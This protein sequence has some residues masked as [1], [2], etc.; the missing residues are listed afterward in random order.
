MPSTV[1]MDR[2][3]ILKRAAAAVAP[4]GSLLIVDHAAAPPWAEKM[5]HHDFPAGEQV[6]AG[7]NLDPAE[8]HSEV[9]TV[10]RTTVGPD[11][12]E[13]TLVDN[14]VHVSRNQPMV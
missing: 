6:L 8:W 12:A 9:S 5:R 4:G 10:E 13:A 11:G 2:T 1:E 3:A 7:L 14:V